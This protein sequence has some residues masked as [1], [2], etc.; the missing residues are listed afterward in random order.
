[1][2]NLYLQKKTLYVHMFIYFLDSQYKL[3]RLGWMVLSEYC[4][5]KVLLLFLYYIIYPQHMY[6]Y[7]LSKDYIICFHDMDMTNMT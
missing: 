5:I 6:M 7:I 3:P 2:Y 1:M 4:R